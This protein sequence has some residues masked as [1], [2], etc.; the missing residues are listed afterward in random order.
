MPHIH[1]TLYR[2]YRPETFDEVLGQDHIVSVLKA[3]IDQKNIAHAYLFAGSK[4]TGKTSIARILARDLKCVEEDIY[5]IDA[6]SNRGIDDIR[7]LRDAVHT[8]PFKSPYKI[9][10][11]DE[12]HMLTK[13][14]FNALL[15]TL[16]EPPAHV[17]FVLATTEK[18]KVLETII[19]RCQV[20]D[21]K[22][23]NQAILK[24][25]AK[26]VAKKEK[27]KIDAGS[28]E[29]IAMLG[30]SSY[31][32]TLGM[33]QKVMSYSVDKKIT[34][35]EAEKITGAPSQELIN[36]FLESIDKEN[37]DETISVINKAKN[38]GIAANIFLKFVLNKLRY[39]LLLRFS[40]NLH[41]EIKED[42]GEG[43]YKILSNL[44]SKAKKLNSSLVRELL[45]A[46]REVNYASIPYLPIELAVIKLAEQKN[47]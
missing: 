1:T 5:E 22:K 6:A 23:P 47:S 28:L 3:S 27:Y 7:E 26:D 9:Y 40:K 8:L 32:D 4:G 15:K 41:K 42:L 20:F 37:I 34:R 16:E 13:D 31:R 43:E 24:Q 33:L 17:I 10:I 44:A 36:S 18:E 12:V 46:Y 11:V 25:L 45:K 39:I 30:D 35:D 19:S 14:A 21:F 29:L 38:L 2:K